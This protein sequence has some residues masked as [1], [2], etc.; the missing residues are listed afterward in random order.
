MYDDGASDS[1]TAYASP[2]A[3]VDTSDD[4]R[5]GHGFDSTIRSSRR[6]APEDGA[7]RRGEAPVEV[8]MTRTREG[9]IIPRDAFP[10]RVRVI[11]TSTGASPRREG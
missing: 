9:R 4:E 6:M 3:R 5:D 8:T 10:S 11:V 7:R 2:R 1:E